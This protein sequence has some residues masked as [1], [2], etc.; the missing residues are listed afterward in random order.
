MTTQVT[1]LRGQM[2]RAKR[3]MPAKEVK[4]VLRKQKVAHVGTVDA[5]GWPM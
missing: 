5:N 2:H 1:D 4:D 3:L